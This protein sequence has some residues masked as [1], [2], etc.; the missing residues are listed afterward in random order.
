MWLNGAEAVDVDGQEEEV[1]LRFETHLI[2]RRRFADYKLRDFV[3][4][5]GA[6]LRPG[7]AGVC[8]DDVDESLG[9]DG[10]VG[11][12]HGK[13]EEARRVGGYRGVQGFAVLVQ[14]GAD[15]RGDEGGAGETV[16]EF[17]EG[18]AAG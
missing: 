4:Q 9:E 18:F 14:G 13:Q 7:P 11:E 12:E 16:G 8:A 5:V 2:Q 1:A 10:V 3:G 6:F 17:D 15:L